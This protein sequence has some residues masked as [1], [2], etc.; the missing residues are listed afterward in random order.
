MSPEELLWKASHYVFDRLDQTSRILFDVGRRVTGALHSNLIL[1]FNTM[2]ALG[3]LAHD[4]YGKHWCARNR[5]Q[6]RQPVRSRGDFAKEWDE[7]SLAALGVLIERH[8]HGAA[9]PQRT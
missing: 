7:N 5:G 3:R 1:D 2:R 8:A 4:E 9:L 6:A